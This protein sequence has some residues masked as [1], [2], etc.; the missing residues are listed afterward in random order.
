MLPVFIIL[1][2]KKDFLENVFT[3]SAVNALLQAF[4]SAMILGCLIRSKNKAITFLA[5]G[6][7]LAIAFNVTHRF[8]Q[9]AGNYHQLLST[10]WLICPLI[11]IVG[12]VMALKNSHEKISFFPR[13]SIHV[14]VSAFILSTSF[15]TLFFVIAGLLISTG[16]MSEIKSF[17]RLPENLVSVLIF[18][19]SLSLLFSKFSANYVSKYLSRLADRVYL[20]Q[21]NMANLDQLNH[22]PSPV[23]EIEKL[24]GFIL[25]IVGEL[26]AANRVKANFLRNM[27]HDFRTPAS[28]IYQMSSSLHKRMPE[29]ELKTKQKRIVDSSTQLM[30]F[31]DEILLYSNLENGNEP[32][33]AQE[34]DVVALINEV[35]AF[36]FPKIEENGLS[37]KTHFS[38][39]SLEYVGYRNHL[40]RILLNLISNAIKFTPKGSIEITACE[41]TKDGEDFMRIVIKD[42]GIGIAKEEQE[43]IFEAFYRVKTN[44]SS[45]LSGIG[46]GLSSVKLMLEEMQ[47]TISLESHLGIGSTFTLLLPLDRFTVDAPNDDLATA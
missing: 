24:D 3:I 20:I 8:S 33:M 38:K 12:F 21:N 41:I 2:L 18:S 27:S 28:G 26:Q 42:T 37:I 32:L 9:E 46:L 44:D 39:E 16:G 1:I 31:L 15:L 14:L 34:L 6:F 23:Y 19:F 10:L 29:D 43:K 40:Y 5:T 30:N 25:K 4:L 45:P 7:L 47:G 17:D 11:L 36:V 35:I 13:N 22:K